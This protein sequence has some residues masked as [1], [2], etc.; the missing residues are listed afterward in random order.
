MR[1]CRSERKLEAMD[2][3]FVAVSPAIFFRA[4][5][6]CEAWITITSISLLLITIQYS[7]PKATV[8]ATLRNLS[9]LFMRTH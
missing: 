5:I 9:L 7:Y 1:S 6:S 2:E 3:N 8:T 4:E